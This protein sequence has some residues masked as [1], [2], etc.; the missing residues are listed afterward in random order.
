MR[1]FN[2]RTCVNVAMALQIENHKYCK[3]C[4]TNVHF[5]VFDQA[6]YLALEGDRLMAS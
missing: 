5:K 4:S 2:L 3:L 1:Y 6:K